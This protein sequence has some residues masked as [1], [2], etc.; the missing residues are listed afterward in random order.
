[1]G[2]DDFNE[3]AQKPRGGRWVKLAA[4]GDFVKGELL[5]M[6]IINR[7]DP[8]GN[9]V[10]SRKT[11]NPRKVTRVRIQTELRED[12]DDDGVRIFDAN[13]SATDALYKAAPFIIGGT[14]AIQL[15]EEPP[16][17]FSQ[18]SYTVAFKAAEPVVSASDLLG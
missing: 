11:G 4:K 3:E 6:E 2:I 14:I 1:M 12:G 16:D 8:E 17:K 10:L 7:T 5:D 13:E 18:A 9:V 15:T